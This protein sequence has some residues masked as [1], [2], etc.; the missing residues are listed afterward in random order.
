M[1]INYSHINKFSSFTKNKN[2][3]FSREEILSVLKKE[4]IDKAFNTIY[5]VGRIMN[6]L[7]YSN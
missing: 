4:T 3:S 5:L 7:P 1:S 6:P 2:Y